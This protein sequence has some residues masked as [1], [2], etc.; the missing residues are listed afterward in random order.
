MPLRITTQNLLLQSR[1]SVC[2]CPNLHS[3]I[4]AMSVHVASFSCGV[5]CTRSHNTAQ[6]TM[7]GPLATLL[8]CVAFPWIECTDMHC[9]HTSKRQCED[10]LTGHCSS[11]WLCFA[12][13]W[14]PVNTQVH[15]TTS[16][17]SPR[18]SSLQWYSHAVVISCVLLV[19]HHNHS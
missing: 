9:M 13:L 4:H 10:W 2:L 11:H 16:D 5:H 12:A 18:V 3:T 15:K 14:P 17:K 8:D 7:T 19:F 6:L 1:W